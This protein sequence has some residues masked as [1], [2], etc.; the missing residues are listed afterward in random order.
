MGSSVVDWKA[1]TELVTDS[2]CGFFLIPGGNST[3]NF[4]KRAMIFNLKSY[5]QH[6]RYRQS[7][8]GK[9]I[10]DQIIKLDSD[11]VELPCLSRVCYQ[12]ELSSPDCLCMLFP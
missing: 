9:T 2:Q 1:N 12:S 8:R 10:L 3:G 4:L 7:Q 6:S 11:W 5:P